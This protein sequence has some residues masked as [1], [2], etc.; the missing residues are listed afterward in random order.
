MLD[1]RLQTLLR[2]ILHALACPLARWGVRANTVTWL[3]FG[4]GV[5]AACA[6]AWQAYA[7]GLAAL[8]LSRAMDGLDG[9][10][11]RCTQP[12]RYGGF[13]DITLDFIFYASIPLGFAIANPGANALAAAVL[14]CAFV[15]TGSSFLA[16]AILAAQSGLAQPAGLR[17]S[18]YYLGGLTEAGETLL[19]FAAMCVWPQHFAAIAYGFACLC[20]LTVVARI[21]AARRSFAAT[22]PPHH[23]S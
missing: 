2:P 21:A 13:L 19:A 8:L 23:E 6:I 4:V 22:P 15:G 17:K 14:L 3:G 10:L 12:T 1:Q 20:L 9:A 7:L 16:F 18:F 11:A 5:L